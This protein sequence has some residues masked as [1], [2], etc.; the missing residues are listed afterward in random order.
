MRTSKKPRKTVVLTTGE[1][2]DF[3]IVR[4]ISVPSDYDMQEASDSFRRKVEAMRLVEPHRYRP[5]VR[6]VRWPKAQ[7]V[8]EALGIK[9]KDTGYG[10]DDLFVEYV[11]QG[12]FIGAKDEPLA[13]EFD[14]STF[15]PYQ[16][17][18]M[19][20]EERAQDQAYVVQAQNNGTLVNTQ[21]VEA[22]CKSLEV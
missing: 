17:L 6:V 13:E 14:F 7:E 2:S 11:L 8:A 12:Q 19:T 15:T 4:I 3:H 10:L 5:W 22:T 16:E 9:F 20:S 1:Y 18:P 21:P